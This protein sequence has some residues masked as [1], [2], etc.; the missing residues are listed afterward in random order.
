MPQKPKAK[1]K[2]IRIGAA[3]PHVRRPPSGLGIPTSTVI[4]VF[5]LYIVY[6]IVKRIDRIRYLPRSDQI[7]LRSLTLVLVNTALI[8]MS[9]GQKR[10]TSTRNA[11]LLRRSVWEN[12]VTSL[13]RWPV[14]QRTWQLHHSTPCGS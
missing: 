13:D 2:E 4:V 10:E 5:A 12:H 3:F 9:W 11:L 8:K 1:P 14:R 6:S 7:T